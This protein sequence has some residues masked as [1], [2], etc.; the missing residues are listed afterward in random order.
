LE[1]FSALAEE[2]SRHPSENC[3]LDF[4]GEF[5]QSAICPISATIGI[6]RSFF[7][8]RRS[9]AAFAPSAKNAVSA[10]G[11][12]LACDDRWAWHRPQTVSLS[13]W[14]ARTGR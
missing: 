14:N 5:P 8:N 11:A 9:H 7:D 3:A 10:G 1:I 6:N 13:Q 2:P 4:K 12:M